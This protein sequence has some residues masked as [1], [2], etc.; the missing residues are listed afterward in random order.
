MLVRER[1]LGWIA[2]EQCNLHGLHGACI[3]LPSSLGH[4][5]RAIDAG[6]LPTGC[7][8]HC[9]LHRPFGS[10]SKLQDPVSSPDRQLR[11]CPAGLH[12]MLPNYTFADDAPDDAAG[13]L[14]LLIAR[15]AVPPRGLQTF[16]PGDCRHV[17]EGMSV[18][19]EVGQAGLAE[20][21]G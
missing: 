14:L 10:T 11:A 7:L 1:Q 8:C 15:P 12:C 3:R 9:W 2:A 19:H 6:H 17:R 13:M 4:G 5:G 21:L 18:P 20:D 16:V